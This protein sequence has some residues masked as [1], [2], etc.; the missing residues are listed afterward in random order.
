MKVVGD[1]KN[2]RGVSFKTIKIVFNVSFINL[3]TASEN[4][5]IDAL[6]RYIKY[7]NC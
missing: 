3:L 6:K 1:I 7:L 4:Y 5:Q 2:R